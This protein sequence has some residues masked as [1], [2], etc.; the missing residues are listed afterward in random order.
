MTS[1]EF[2][3][4]FEEPNTNIVIETQEQIDDIQ[5]DDDIVYEIDVYNNFMASLP[6][7]EQNDK[8]I[9]DKYIKL[10]RHL[11]HLKNEAKKTDIDDLDDYT[12]LRKIY[13]KEFQVDWIFPVVL[14]KKKIYKKVDIDDELQDETLMDEY[15]QSTSDK[16]IQYEDFIEELNKN[17]QYQDEFK[18]DKLS[19]KTYR[20]LTYDI[21]EPY[22]IKTDIKKKD[23]GFHVYMNQYAQL[24]RY[25]NIDNKFW[26]T[27]NVEGPDKFSYEQFDADGKFIGT[28]TAQLNNGAYVNV[29]GFLILAN[30]QSTILDALN[31]SPFIDRIRMIGSA[32]KIKKNSSAIIEMKGH[33]LKNGDK[34]MID[35]SDCEPSIDGEYSVKIINENEFMIPVNL[36]EGKEGTTANIYAMTH[37]NMDRI[38]LKLD[39]DYSGKLN[40][41]ATLYIFPEKNIEEEDWKKLCKKVIPSLSTIVDSEEDLKTAKTIDEVNSIL[42]KFNIEFNNLNYDNYFKITEIFDEQY[43]I[44]REEKKRDDLFIKKISENRSKLV[45]M[46]I[47]EDILFGD[48]YIYH[49]EVL[50][51][52]GSYP[53]TELDSVASRY[54]W[55][56][57]SSDYGKLYFLIV[58]NE[59]ISEYKE[60]TT[61]DIEKR[62]KDLKVQIEDI[63]KQ[64][65]KIDDKVCEKRKITPVVVYP[66]FDKLFQ[67]NGKITQFKKGDYAIIESKKSHENGAIYEWNGMNWT[68]NAFIESVDDLC[69]FDV[70]KIS[71]FDIEKLKCLFKTA[72]KSKNKIRLDRKVDLLKEE[73]DYI[74]MIT[75]PD[76]EM[77][78]KDEIQSAKLRLQI[79][80]RKIIDTKQKDTIEI[81]EEDVDE[82]YLDIMK[83]TD[84]DTRDYYRNL[85]IKKDGILINKDIYSIR[86]K[87]KICCGHYYYFLRM[88]EGSHSNYNKMMNDM[89]SI[90]GTNEE[91]GMIY[92]SHDGRPLTLIDYDTSEGLSK[93]T[94][95]VDKQRESVISNEDKLK[96]EI[97]E[98]I[99]QT[100]VEHDTFDCSGMDLRKELMSMG[101][102]IEDIA[103]A[104]DICL[105]LNTINSKTGI[106]LRKSTFI[107]I[108]ADILQFLQKIPDQTKFKQ[109]ELLKMK[110]MGLD[111]KKVDTKLIAE[112]YSNLM[113]IKKCSYIGAR[114]LITYQ[115]L[116]PFQ[117]PIGKRTGVI[118]EGFGPEYIA[119]LI[120]ESRIMPIVKTGKNGNPITIYLPLGKI[121]DEV[122]KAMKDMEYLPSIKKLHKDKKDHD[123]KKVISTEEKDYIRKQNVKIAEAPKI[124]DNFIK[125]VEKAKK[126]S[127]FHNF[128]TKLRERQAFIAQEIIDAVNEAV[129]TTPNKEIENPKTME[130]SGL[131][132]EVSPDRSYYSYISDKTKKNIEELLDESRENMYYSQLFLNTGYLMKHY[133]VKNRKFEVKTKN[134]GVVNKEYHKNVFLTYVQTGVFKGELH[135]YDEKN[136]CILTG[137]TK[138]Q[139]LR[140]EYT[141]SDVNELFQFIIK[142]KMKKIYKGGSTEDIEQM[143]KMENEMIDSIDIEQLKKESDKNLQRTINLFVEKFVRFLNKSGNRS[144]VS[145]L[146]ERIEGLGLYKKRNEDLRIRMD[147]NPNISPQDII[148]F[149]NNIHRERIHHLKII[150]NQYFRK[151]MSII[152]NEYD[153]VENIKEIPDIESEYSIEIQK[154][155]Y[156]REYFLKKY[157]VKRDRDLFQQL[158]FDIS[159]KVISNITA[160][161]DEWD[162]T[163]TK[164]D[165]I[166]EFN[167][168]NLVNS[169]MYILMRNL[170][171]FISSNYDSGDI[172]KNKI[173]SQFIMD[174]LDLIRAD[175]D[176]M[177][178]VDGVLIEGD[179]RTKEALELDEDDKKGELIMVSRDKEEK[180]EKDLSGVR[181]KF[182]SEYKKDNE[183]DPTENEIMDYLD[184]YE[185]EED[186]EKEIED[187]EYEEAPITDDTLD[188]GEKPQGGEGGEYDDF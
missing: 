102:K 110:E 62:K 42:G 36:S 85:L 118:F 32:T 143:T 152:S 11:I 40:K 128:Q 29:I 26:Q 6:I 127:D 74:D 49:K 83:I 77:K 68:Q 172:E 95:E 4:F 60:T 111:M 12:D 5:I 87:K 139:I 181:D 165:K 70:Q 157:L 115:T 2:S 50:S 104:K 112:K 18:R 39:S 96:E 17:I 100:D 75:K 3:K 46:N 28:K 33:N 88:N 58:E 44:A 66:S 64:I 93:S 144:F 123:R 163:Y 27:Y 131:Q 186:N 23:V 135:Q 38:D 178:V 149:E 113:I 160:E 79:Y 167:L 86:T 151:Y 51:Y 81:F 101:F 63:E 182:I 13:D 129:S 147:E 155:I 169:L 22:I 35:N 148:E 183:K 76:I 80:M 14:D 45:Q 132:E 92:C 180:E 109:M 133:L 171:R 179:F 159:S 98:S 166:V 43:L 25:F 59:K 57:K 174:I 20:K 69:L 137:E 108:I 156:D 140:K 37:L 154:Y 146:R 158:E 97:M 107:S 138:D 173:I 31:G 82:L 170:E 10:S 84:M 7:Y 162:K 142:K 67:D 72:C 1:N 188:I 122:M 117:S 150:I 134:L 15:V 90:Y 126:F 187:E 91:N 8:K 161:P 54:N 47:K 19:F 164:I 56:L 185:K 136:V 9:Q 116:I 119:L 16:G 41:K 30:D 130:Y 53:Q 184:N 71:N 141:D 175:Y 21:Q 78:I 120:E 55:L 99:I 125:E 106:V 145:E 103:K 168:K 114:L 124:S 177:D 89:V 105:K 34:I 176:K 121:K 65:K 48:K 61:G 94:G 73:I 52:Y 153:I 24:L